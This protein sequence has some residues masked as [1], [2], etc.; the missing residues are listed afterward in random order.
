MRIAVTL[1][2]ILFSMSQVPPAGGKLK[3]VCQRPN[4]S[5]REYCIQTEIHAGWCLNG[6]FCCLPL[7]HQPQVDPTTPMWTEAN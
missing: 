6:W 2:T 7:G 5:C 1:F 3:E 4:G